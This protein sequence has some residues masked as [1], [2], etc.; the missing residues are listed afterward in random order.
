M[1][2]KVNKCSYCSA[3]VVKD[4]DI[5]LTKEQALALYMFLNNAWLDRDNYELLSSALRELSKAMN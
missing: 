5:L 4:G 3:T 1:E 2:V